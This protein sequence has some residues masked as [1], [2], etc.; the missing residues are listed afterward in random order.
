MPGSRQRAACRIDPEDDDAIEVLVGD[1]QE[2]PAGIDGKVARVLDPLGLVFGLGEL[3]R[4]G[5]DLITD[6]AV[7]PA[8]RAEQEPARGWTWTSAG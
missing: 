4:L 1:E 8:V 2:L 6:D 7:V 5:I 3:A